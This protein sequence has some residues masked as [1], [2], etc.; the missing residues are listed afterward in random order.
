MAKGHSRIRGRTMLARK[1]GG[2][3]RARDGNV[4][5]LAHSDTKRLSAVAPRR[6]PPLVVRCAHECYA[7]DMCGGRR[8]MRSRL[9]E[10]RHR[11]SA[12][13][14]AYGVYPPSTCSACCAAGSTIA[15]G[16]F[17]ADDLSRR[18]AGILF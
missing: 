2:R 18:H 9:D 16:A 14:W 8:T 13:A 17:R 15:G 5:T 12:A 6:P 3:L 4:G 10:F 11:F 7:T 1:L